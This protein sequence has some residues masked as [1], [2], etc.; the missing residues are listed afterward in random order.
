M[1]AASVFKWVSV[2]GL[3]KTQILIKK[4]LL[5][6]KNYRII[7]HT[8]D[9]STRE[10]EL[11]RS[12]TLYYTSS[13]PAWAT[14]R[15]LDSETKQAKWWSLLSPLW[16]SHTKPVLKLAYLPFY[17]SLVQAAL[18]FRAGF[19]GPWSLTCKFPMS[20]QCSHEDSDSQ[21]QEGSV[22][23]DACVQPCEDTK[24]ASMSA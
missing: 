24:E 10:V 9:S 2:P 16:K 13:K 12:W 14:W 22:D 21:L 7:V 19:Q 17:T 1:S 23:T 6:S 15:E 20:F 11:G 8:C 18:Q 5:A 3:T 4:L